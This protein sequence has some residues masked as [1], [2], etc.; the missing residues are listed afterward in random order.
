M[1][2]KAKADIIIGLAKELGKKDFLRVAMAITKQG[3]RRISA[4]KM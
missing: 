3:K 4:G 1:T 2:S